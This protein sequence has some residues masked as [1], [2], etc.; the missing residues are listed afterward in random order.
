[1]FDW[2]SFLDVA[3]VLHAAGGD[4]LPTEATQRT[5]VGR[6]YYA[7][8]GHARLYAARYFNLTLL[9][10]SDE[11]ERLISHL[12]RQG[13]HRLARTL[14]Q[15]R[16][17]RNQCDYE[18]VVRDLAAKADSALTDAAYVIDTLVFY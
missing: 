16:R 18:E 6:A 17:S 3:R 14:D 13:Y 7:A 2:S 9:P 5:V 11:H 4:A 10:G 15:L 1:M 12:R 8:F